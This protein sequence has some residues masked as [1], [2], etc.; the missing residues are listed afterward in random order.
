MFT[1]SGVG[2]SIGIVLV[3]IGIVA[4]WIGIRQYRQKGR[5]FSIAAFQAGEEDLEKWKTKKAY[6]GLAWGYLTLACVLLLFAAAFLLDDEKPA[7]VGAGLA[8]SQMIVGLM[9]FYFKI[10]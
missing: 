10:R 9:R 4:F 8:L 1:E 6:R 3:L 2:M 5:L 7:F